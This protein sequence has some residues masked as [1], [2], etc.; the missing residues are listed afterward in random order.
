[1]LANK[2]DRYKGRGNFYMNKN[3]QEI[4]ELYIN[5]EQQKKEEEKIE[6]EEVILI[7]PYEISRSMSLLIRSSSFINKEID[8]LLKYIKFVKFSTYTRIFQPLPY[9]QS[10]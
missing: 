7:K 1:M 3:I 10:L 8:N 6:D 9:Y 5:E 4:Q 2:L